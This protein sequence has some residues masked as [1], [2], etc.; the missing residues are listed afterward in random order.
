MSHMEF[1]SRFDG[2]NCLKISGPSFY[3]RKE[4]I[5][6]Y[7]GGVAGCYVSSGERASA[8]S[9][10]QCGSRRDLGTLLA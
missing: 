5:Q 7:N 1:K 9:T 8:L 3:R 4:R 10:C 6:V 2:K